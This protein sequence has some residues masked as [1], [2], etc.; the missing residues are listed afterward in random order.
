MRFLA[1][2]FV[3]LVMAIFAY[4]AP[5]S[6]ESRGIQLAQAQY[7]IWT[8]RDGQTF[9][10]DPY[11]GEIVR[12]VF[13]EGRVG[14]RDD[15]R[16]RLRR[17]RREN[18]LERELGRLFDLRGGRRY[19]DD[20]YD[21]S[22][23][24]R[25]EYTDDYE[26]PI[27]RRRRERPQ[28]RRKQQKPTP[29][30]KSI[31]RLPE[32]NRP[33]TRRT[34]LNGIVKPNYGRK[35]MAQLQVVLDR[36]GFSPGVIDGKWGSNV[37]NAMAAW[38][39]AKGKIRLSDPTVLS[40]ELASSGGNAFY[41]HTLTNADVTGPFTPKI[42]IDYS[43]KALLKNLSYTSVYEKM[44][45]R[46]HMSEAYLRFLNPGKNFKKSGTRINVVAPGTVKRTK[47]HYIIADKNRE[48]VRA[49]DRNGKLVTAYP[50][51]IGSSAT[52]SPSGT[53]SIERIALDPNYT[54]NPKKNFQQGDNDKILTIPP[55]PNGPVGSVWIALS[56][57]TYGI[58]GTPNP[59]TI[60]K[61]NSHGCI[62]L[63]NWDAREL[64]KMVSK[65]VTVKFVE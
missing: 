47:V 12:E 23:R 43:Q 27:Q 37:A 6:A 22:G 17:Q 38:N 28:E 46:F 2:S 49:Y 64:A 53:H 56:K 13:R 52:P 60:G 65:G 3:I 59:D 42:P 20:D 62:R 25:D 19:E 48:Q 16:R 40:K 26:E 8:N 63:T 4:V 7:D 5:S 39:E 1:F 14:R 9:L 50:A 21:D 61:T 24:Y 57:P 33:T 15:R 55:G 18:R 10:I 54:Y 44:A 51:T 58:H 30:N 41:Q 32:N 45:E 31:A 36:A 34:T 11:T 35:K 29:N